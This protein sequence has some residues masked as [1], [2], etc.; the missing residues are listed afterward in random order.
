MT[1]TSGQKRGP[2]IQTDSIHDEQ[3]LCAP[4]L[5]KHTSWVSA[6][7][8]NSMFTHTHTHNAVCRTVGTIT[9]LR[10]IDGG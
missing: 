2:I 10:G 6:L 5:F 8:N 3:G 4:S 1:R 9:I 7:C